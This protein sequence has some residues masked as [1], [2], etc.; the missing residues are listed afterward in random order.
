[1][2]VVEEMQSPKDVDATMRAQRDRFL[3]FS[4]AASD[5]LIEVDSDGIITYCVGRSAAIFGHQE[6]AMIG[7]KVRSLVDP[8]DA[9]I[10]D[11]TLRRITT[12]GRSDGA[13]LRIPK[14]DGTTV[15]I[16]LS[17]LTMP[18]SGG[19]HLTVSRARGNEVTNLDK[20]DRD[21]FTEIAKK[22]AKESGE[23]GE[24][25]HMTLVSLDEAALNKRMDADQA[26]TMVDGLRSQ[27]RAW[28]V[29]GNSVGKLA[30]G[31]YGVIH[32]SSVTTESLKA[33]IAETSVTL[34]PT[35]EGIKVSTGDIGL[36]GGELSDEDMEKALTYAI[37]KFIADPNK[38]VT[39]ESLT[40]GYEDMM[41]QALAQVTDFRQMI[42]NNRFHFFYQPIVHLEDWKVHHYEAL[43]RV[44]TDG[45]YK[46]PF[47]AVTFAEEFGIVPELDVSVCENAVRILTQGIKGNKDAHIAVNVSGISMS[48]RGF[49]EKL[50][51]LLTKNRAI[52]NQLLIEVTES[53]EITDLELCN[54][55]LQQFRALNCKVCI[56]DFGAGSA[57]FQYLRALDVDYVKIDGIYV[58]DAA[59]GTR[60]GEPFIRAIGTMC[61]DLGIKTIAE[62]VEDVKTVELL[63][64]SFIDYSQGYYFG[65]PMKETTMTNL[66]KKPEYKV[67]TKRTGE[68]S[69]W[70]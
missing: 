59:K 49:I 30:D 35:G 51:R 19:A 18:G 14:V 67:S 53:A 33:R 44:L 10:V 38:P 65:K 46:A 39:M 27:M 15:V 61:R 40:S 1:M 48:K 7:K 54:A 4:F 70:S 66:P 37:S 24:D 20:I 60:H 45:K 25:Y 31:T 21:A 34:D 28:S 42:A 64:N 12:A 68:K 58:R 23:Y 56:D 47:E 17:G 26:N 62:Y 11:E 6:P 22:R 55:A 52:C 13:L 57:T 29:G 69:S 2:N 8:T 43:G 5:V 63:R 3:A 36:D 32:D 41:V 50:I 16:R 9:L